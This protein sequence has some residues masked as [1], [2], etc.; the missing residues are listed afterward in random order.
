MQSVT[1]RL[2]DFKSINSMATRQV[3]VQPQQEGDSGTILSIAV[4]GAVGYLV[5]KAMGPLTAAKDV[6]EDVGS[7]ISSGFDALTRSADK[8]FSWLH[9]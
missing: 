9:G 3:Q 6:V 4:V 5:Y 1:S 2:E 8:S 7:S